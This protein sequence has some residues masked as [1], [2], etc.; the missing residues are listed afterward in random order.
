MSYS[1]MFKFIIIGDTGTL[2]F[3]LQVW[4]SPA[5]CSSSSISDFGRSMK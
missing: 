4:A 5:C 1:Y 3:Q 2:S